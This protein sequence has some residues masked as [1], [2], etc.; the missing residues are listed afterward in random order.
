[1]NRKVV[2]RIT[3]V[4]FIVG[5]MIAVQYNTVK[6]PSERDTRDTWELRQELSEEKKT[7]FSIT[8]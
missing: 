7:T 4:S 5:I 3:I 8:L 6:E 1:M 2:T